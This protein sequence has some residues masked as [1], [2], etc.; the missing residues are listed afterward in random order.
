MSLIGVRGFSLIELVMVIFLIGVLSALGIGLFASRSAFSPLLASQ[1]LASATLLA[2]QAAL[3]GNGA[4]ALRIE[5][6][7]DSFRFVVGPGTALERGYELARE[8]TS[9]SIV[10]HSLPLLLTFDAF[11]A[12][13]GGVSLQLIFSGDSRFETCLSSLGAVYAGSCLP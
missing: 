11:G 13:T 6:T 1:Q 9:L 5:Q 7:A 8:G 4:S 2:Q 10:D 3:A 12:P